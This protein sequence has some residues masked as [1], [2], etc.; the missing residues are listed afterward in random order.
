MPFIRYKTVKGRRYYQL[1]RNYREAGVHRQQVICHLGPHESIDAAIEAEHQRIK[2]PLS[3]E[4]YRA[5]Y[6]RERAAGAQEE[7]ALHGGVLEE[8][9]ANRSL[10]ELWA[11]PGFS[12]SDFWE[13]P[14]WSRAEYS[15]V[16]H[17]ARRQLASYEALMAARR[18]RLDKLLEARRMYF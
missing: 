3:W 6:W 17:E 14:E 2:V 10:A 9:E 13:S 15:N 18:T 8:A 16:Y 7:A 12:E 5:S 4:A 11:A 1:V